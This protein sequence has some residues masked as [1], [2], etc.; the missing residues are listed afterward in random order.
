MGR[1]ACTEP[2]C[3]YKGVLYLYLYH[4]LKTYGRVE[5]KLHT[6]INSAADGRE[7]SVLHPVLCL[8]ELFSFTVCTG[9]G[10]HGLILFVPFNVELLY[11]YKIMT[12]FVR[13]TA[14]LLTNLVTVLSRMQRILLGTP[15]F[16]GPSSCLWMSVI[17]TLLYH[18]LA[19]TLFRIPEI[20]RPQELSSSSLYRDIVSWLCSTLQ[21]VCQ[22]RPAVRQHSLSIAM[23][24]SS[25]FQVCVLVRTWAMMLCFF[26]THCSLRLIV[27][28]WLV[29]VPTFAT[30][31][32]YACYH[33]RA[34]SGGRWNGRR[35]MSGNFT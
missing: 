1:T 31:R 11:D 6:F 15:D 5:V 20:Q 29:D 7:L 28:S 18:T 34:P 26:T 13:R 12:N 23:L 27:R 14:I 16:Y 19:L 2:Q 8:W 33:A 32:L 9:T 25:N 10:R 17:L 24:C 21:H 3:L 4:A 22:W 35:E 30:R